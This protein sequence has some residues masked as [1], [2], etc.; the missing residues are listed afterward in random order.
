MVLRTCTLLQRRGERRATMNEIL[1]GLRRRRTRTR[2]NTN[3]NDTE[4]NAAGR[5]WNARV[6]RKQ[7]K[8]GVIHEGEGHSVPPNCSE[9]RRQL[10]P[11]LA[12]WSKFASA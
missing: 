12:F 3:P 11:E 7:D 10:E 2:T 8:C 6:L 5:S 9:E 1:C 4:A